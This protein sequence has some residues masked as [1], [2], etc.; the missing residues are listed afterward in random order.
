[1][2]HCDWKCFADLSAC[3]LCWSQI[4]LLCPF[5]LPNQYRFVFFK[6]RIFSSSV[7][8][9]KRK[10][11]IPQRLSAIQVA[12]I[13]VGSQ[14][15]CPTYNWQSLGTRVCCQLI[16]T[17]CLPAGLSTHGFL[18][19]IFQV[20]WLHGWK[21]CRS[22]WYRCAACECC[23]PRAYAKNHSPFQANWARGEK[24]GDS[25]FPSTKQC[26]EIKPAPVSAMLNN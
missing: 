22:H 16:K 4:S 7:E 8:K 10:K 9:K 2:N 12:E 21:G 25:H 15:C 26:L 13:T 19:Q 23:Q 18:A 24:K 3:P 14:D 1:M 11:L 6:E 20:V 5:P 17:R